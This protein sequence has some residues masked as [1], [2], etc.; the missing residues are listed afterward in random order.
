MRGPPLPAIEVIHT[1]VLQGK[2]ELKLRP[3]VLEPLDDSL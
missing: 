1:N 2:C 3:T